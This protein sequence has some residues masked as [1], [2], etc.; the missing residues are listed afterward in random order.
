MPVGALS[1]FPIFQLAAT[2]STPSSSRH[3]YAIGSAETAPADSSM[4]DAAKQA[5]SLSKPTVTDGVSGALAITNN[6]ALTW[7][8]AAQE[9][10]G[11]S[12][13]QGFGAYED[14]GLEQST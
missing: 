4:C 3:R 9:P 11:R 8:T 7:A 10:T 2:A 6:H 12:R 13:S 14:D 5:R 1:S